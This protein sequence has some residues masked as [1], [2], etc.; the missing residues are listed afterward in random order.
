MSN[1]RRRMNSVNSQR[2]AA[3][4][5]AER[6]S[7]SQLKMWTFFTWALISLPPVADEFEEREKKQMI[8]EKNNDLIEGWDFEFLQMIQ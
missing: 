4:S 3:H 8:E 7:E 1:D 2:K 6:E 5:T